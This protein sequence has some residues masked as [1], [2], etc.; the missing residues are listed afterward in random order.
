M[1]FKL[2]FS[3][4]SKNVFQIMSNHLIIGLGG[5]GGKIIRAFRKTIFQEFRKTEPE[6]VN[7]GYLY[8]Y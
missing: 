5:T 8:V 2:S 6:E 4:L 3:I 1:Q 7:V